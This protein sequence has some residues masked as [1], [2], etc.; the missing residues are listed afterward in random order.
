[1]ESPFRVA[2]LQQAGKAAV[3][4]NALS[5]N[6]NVMSST[7][8]MPT[9]SPSA[10]TIKALPP[11]A[12]ATRIAHGSVRIAPSPDVAPT[13]LETLKESP[14]SGRTSLAAGTQGIIDRL[15]SASGFDI[16]GDGKIGRSD[17][18]TSDA[19]SAAQRMTE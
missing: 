1:M 19:A 8:S 10:T 13:R 18:K 17:D 3:V 12:G 6:T 14:R 5:K 16:D 2:A 11:I 7:S 9:P 4:T 15:E